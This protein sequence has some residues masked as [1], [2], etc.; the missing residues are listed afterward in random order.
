MGY[1]RVKMGSDQLGMES[2][3]AWATPGAFTEL[4]SSFACYEDGSNCVKHTEY[5]DPALKHAAHLVGE[6]ASIE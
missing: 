5:A 1:Y 4:D 2:G 3:C 6:V